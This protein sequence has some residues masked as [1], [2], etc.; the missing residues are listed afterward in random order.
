MAR[1]KRKIKSYTFL[2]VPDNKDTTKSFNISALSVKIL[3]L[4]AILL[5]VIIIEL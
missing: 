4:T 3:F 2:V 5:I 1:K